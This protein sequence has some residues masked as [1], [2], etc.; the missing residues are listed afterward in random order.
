MVEELGSAINLGT[1][2]RLV[3]SYVRSIAIAMLD[4]SSTELEPGGLGANVQIGGFLSTRL[5]NPTFIVDLGETHLAT[6]RE[7]GVHVTLSRN[8]RT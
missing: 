6:E 7:F 1:P 2:C 3:T 4:T 8:P 5:Y